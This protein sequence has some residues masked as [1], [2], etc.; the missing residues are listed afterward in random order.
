MRRDGLQG[1]G[2]LA[3]EGGQ[4]F[5][6]GAAT[7][8][9]AAQFFGDAQAVDADGDGALG[10]EVGFD[11]AAELV[12]NTV[13]VARQDG[14]VGDFETE[15]MAEEGGYGKPVGQRADGGGFGEGFQVAQRGVALHEQ[16][17]NDKQQ[18]GSQQQAAGLAAAALQPGAGGGFSGLA[19]QGVHGYKARSE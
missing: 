11:E 1:G 14:G 16:R 18:Y 17:G 13:L 9:P 19:G 5:L 12:G 6:A 15:R 10:Q 8:Q 3:G 2:D 4:P 7:S